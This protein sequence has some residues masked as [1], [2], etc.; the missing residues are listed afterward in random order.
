MCM[1][2]WTSHDPSCSQEPPVCGRSC[3]PARLPTA[4]AAAEGPGQQPYWS[5]EAQAGLESLPAL[6]HLRCGCGR[7][8]VEASRCPAGACSCMLQQIVIF[9]SSLSQK[10]V[11]GTSS[12]PCTPAWASG[13]LSCK[14]K[15]VFWL[16]R[17]S[18]PFMT[19]IHMH[20]I[21]LCCLCCNMRQHGWQPCQFSH[22]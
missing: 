15:A 3:G 20:R 7:V 22:P 5:L 10:A 8:A 12:G 21:Q 17:P 18:S 13:N 9:V 1:L 19:S 11:Q 4:P 2:R 16:L 6:Q 14:G